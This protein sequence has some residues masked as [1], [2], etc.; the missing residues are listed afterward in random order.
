MTVQIS[1]KANTLLALSAVLKSAEVLPVYIVYR[2]DFEKDSS[3]VYDELIRSLTGQIVIRSSSSDEDSF[4]Q[5]NAGAFETFLDVPALEKPQVISKIGKVFD[6]YENCRPRDQVLIQPQLEGVDAAGVIFTGDMD[7]LSP[8]YVINF[9]STGRTDGI[10]AGTA[11]EDETH[12]VFKSVQKHRLDSANPFLSKIVSVCEE[13][14]LLVGNQYLDIEFAVQGAKIFIFQVRPI[15]T[16]QK[17][18]LGKLNYLEGLRRVQKKIEKLNSP[19]PNLLGRNTVFGVMPDWNPAEIIGIRPKKLA[20]SLYKELITDHTWAYQRDNYGY[21]NLRSHP[22]L[23]SLLG[24]PFID[25]RVSLNSFIPKS[26]DDKIGEKLANY[27]LSVLKQNPEFH[28]KIEFEIVFSCFHF[29]STAELGRLA[30]HG[31]TKSEIDRIDTS[32][33][34]L[35]KEVISPE[36]GLM[37]KDIEKSK[38]LD[39]KLASILDSKLSLIDK[40]YWLVQDVKRYGTLPFAGIARSAFIATQLIHSMEKVRLLSKSQVQDFF[41]SLQTVSKSLVLDKKRLDLQ[42]FLGIYGHLR[43]GTYD[44]CSQ[45]Y[46]E[47][48]ELYFGETD[49][50][51]DKIQESEFSVSTKQAIEIDDWLQTN[52]FGIDA[53]ELLAFCRSAIEAREY[54]KFKFT[55]H[56]SCIL[57]LILEFGAKYD[58]TREQISHMDLEFILEKYSNLDNGDVASGLA[59]HINVNK[60]HHLLTSGVKFPHLI[61]ESNDIYCFQNPTSVTNFVTL[62]EITGQTVV[63]D[64]IEGFDFTRKIALIKSADPGFD[65]LFTKNISGLV[66]CY[67]GANSHMAIR[68]AELGIPAAIGCGEALFNSLAKS[69]VIQIDALNRNIRVLAP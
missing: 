62:K 44:V 9:D 61:F 42:E 27:Y 55:R 23:I 49:P 25:V 33:L 48:V 11:V 1:T 34:D 21:R 35:T 8:Y 65:F 57:D 28:D 64:Q 41:N 15:V 10:T 53:V 18:D 13:L 4:K 31:F 7:N 20:L 66:T 32:L 47:N 22:I 52:G 29:N 12:T 24:V 30:K 67:G 45:K 19:H 5:S 3:S 38:A 17:V 56:V 60:E 16:T 14:E 58:V 40:I 26:L 37:A 36:T 2:D 54:S 63:V 43:P 69:K 6:S 39:N 59:E 46:S 51:A 68:C 50:T